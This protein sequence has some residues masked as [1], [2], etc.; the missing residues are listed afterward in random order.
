MQCA[1]HDSFLASLR[2]HKVKR[3]ILAG[4]STAWAVQATARDAHDRDY[5]VVNFAEN[6]HR[7]N[8]TARL[9]DAAAA[10]TEAMAAALAAKLFDRVSHTNPT[11]QPMA[12]E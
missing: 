2:A 4:V 1:G 9:L 7:I 5:Q 8:A 3:L 11:K 12:A 6:V 10:K